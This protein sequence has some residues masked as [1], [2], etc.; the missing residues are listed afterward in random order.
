ME[1]RVNLN[2]PLF[3]CRKTKEYRQMQCADTD[4]CEE[5]C[6]LFDEALKEIEQLKDNS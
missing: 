6:R 5:K 4:N 1:T 3:L 2:L